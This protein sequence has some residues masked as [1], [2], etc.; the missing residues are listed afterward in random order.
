MNDIYLDHA[1]TTPV[2][3]E[4]ARAMTTA[5]L[6]N[7]GNPSSLHPWG[8]KA[9]RLL[10]ESRRVVGEALG[11]PASSILFCASGSEANQW[12]IVGALKGQTITQVICSALEHP[13]VW[14]T[15]EGLGGDG[16]FAPIALHHLPVTPEGQVSLVGLESLFARGPSFISCMWVN[17]ETGVIQPVEEIVKMAR[18][19]PHPVVVHVDGVQALGHMP[20][21]LGA[22]GADF[23]SFSG[24]K[25]GAPKGAAF[26]YRR[27]GEPAVKLGKLLEGGGQEFGLR[28]GTENTAFAAALAVAVPLA[29]GFLKENP[30]HYPALGREATRL[31]TAL[32][33]VSLNAPLELGTGAVVSLSIEGVESDVLQIRLGNEGI[34]VS[35]GAACS[36]GARRP[37]R[38]LTAM[39]LPPE[40]VSGSLRLSFGPHTR[41]DEIARAAEVLGKLLPQLRGQ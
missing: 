4:V 24:H 13:S 8:Q 5:A 11:T 29:T 38:V 22:L 16:R 17:N 23:V 30:K 28:G 40:K 18:Q 39:G 33:G 21:D 9:G 19:A 15:V 34:C 25:I 32:A 20:I 1:A 31:F 36:S 7:W 27:Q 6:E 41:G 2:H 26:L 14:N 35:G 12:A 37:S 3:P 10:R